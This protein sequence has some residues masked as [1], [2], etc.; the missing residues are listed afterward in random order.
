MPGLEPILAS[1]ERSV[2]SGIKSC[3]SLH[4]G[5][6]DVEFAI[7][8]NYMCCSNVLQKYR[9]LELN[10][11]YGYGIMFQSKCINLFKVVTYKFYFHGVLLLK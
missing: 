5:T 9:V 7:S 11:Q 8:K 2:Y 6:Q 4:R 10:Y 3:F 1:D